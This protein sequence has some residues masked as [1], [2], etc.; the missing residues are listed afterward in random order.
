MDAIISTPNSMSTPT[1]TARTMSA[2]VMGLDN[3]LD[4]IHPTPIVVPLR[5]PVRNMLTAA[6]HRGRPQ[7]AQGWVVLTAERWKS[8]RNNVEGKPVMF[9]PVDGPGESHRDLLI[10]LTKHTRADQ[11]NGGNLDYITQSWP[12]V[13]EGK[14]TREKEEFDNTGRVAK[15]DLA[16]LNGAVK[17]YNKILG[18]MGRCAFPVS[19]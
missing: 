13:G 14:Q 16:P 6:A 18:E 1:A 3:R 8:L 10:R 5:H 2:S 11:I 17:W 12:K 9:F 19:P 7:P 15:Y 4:W